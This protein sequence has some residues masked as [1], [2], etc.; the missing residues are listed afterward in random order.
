MC[1]C[2]CVGMIN[3]FPHDKDCMVWTLSI[4]AQHGVRIVRAVSERLD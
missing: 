2:V 3:V 4:D 1:V